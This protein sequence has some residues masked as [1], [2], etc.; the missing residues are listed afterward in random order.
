MEVGVIITVVVVIDALEHNYHRWNNVGCSNLQC[1]GKTHNC[2]GVNISTT[3]INSSI[4]I[5]VLSIYHIE[6]AWSSMILIP[7][8]P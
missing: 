5:Q 1:N 2:N 3:V 6:V 4:P 7:L 8:F